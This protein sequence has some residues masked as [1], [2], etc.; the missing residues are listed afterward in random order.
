MESDTS[1]EMDLINFAISLLPIG[2]QEQVG[3][4][5]EFFQQMPAQPKPGNLTIANFL[6]PEMKQII[7]SHPI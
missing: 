2:K 7:S 6:P 4:P 5:E 1:S 3:Q